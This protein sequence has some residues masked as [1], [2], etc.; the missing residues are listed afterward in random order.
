MDIL[1]VDPNPEIFWSVCGAVS[2]D[3]FIVEHLPSLE[4]ADEVIQRRFPKI[5]IINGNLGI[6]P[7][8]EFVYRNRNFVFARNTIFFVVTAKKEQEERRD[9]L[10]AGV[11]MV[12]HKEP[13]LRI[14]EEFLKEIILWFLKPPQKPH[15]AFKHDPVK[16]KIPA[17]WRAFGRI[18]WISPEQILI[19]TNVELKENEFINF[20]MPLLE[21]LEIKDAQLK[22]LHKNTNGMYYHYKNSYLCSIVTKKPE[23]LKKR[24]TS[25]ILN[26]QSIS[27]PKTIKAIYIEQDAIY[28]QEIQ[29][30]IK[31][32][33]IFCARGF[34]NLLNIKDDLDFQK[35]K[36]III[37][38]SFIKTDSKNFN[39][40]RNYIKENKAYCITY[41]LEK[42]TKLKELQKNY[43]FALHS[44]SPL[45]F[46]M[47][48]SM[49]QKLESKRS[50]E[51]RREDISKIFFNKAS[52]YGR[53]SFNSPAKITQ[54]S[55]HGIE[56]D[57]PYSMSDN[58]NFEVSSHLFKMLNI[59]KVQYLKLVLKKQ[60]DLEPD[61][62]Y[63][64]GIFIGHSDRE[65]EMIKNSIY[66]IRE[67]GF[68]D[69]KA[70]S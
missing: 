66:I 61:S 31:K 53:I 69:F 64:R 44:S 27:R 10:V 26:N 15:E 40:I 33:A 12:L 13:A 45:D 2:N 11:E 34:P 8:T 28:R 52:V 5:V 65:K 63:H 23:L 54:L 59:A 57:L 32:D 50:I 29:K 9:F 41:S 67:A 62:T 35:P 37:N 58:T 18:G 48:E 30:M 6:T 70:S 47:L 3:N 36:L 20:N 60:N 19:E 24:L 7:T 16:I 49:A 14:N 42:T 38:N 22:C 17:Q 1:V 43:P 39:I 68:E 4:A 51:E 46:A 25:W 21:E 56:I 55:E